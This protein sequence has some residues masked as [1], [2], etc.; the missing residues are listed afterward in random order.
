[1][2]QAELERVRSREHQKREQ[3][4]IFALSGEAEVYNEDGM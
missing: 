2:L 3:A 4:K 1:V